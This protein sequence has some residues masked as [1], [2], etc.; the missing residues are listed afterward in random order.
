MAKVVV[1]GGGWSGCAAAIAAR[2]AGAEVILLERTDSLLGTGLVGGI[3]RNNGRFT[4]AEEII[5]LGCGDMIL[6]TDKAARHRDV[7]FPGHEHATLYD[8]GKI[9][10][11]VRHYLQDAGVDI[12]FERR[13][14]AAATEDGTVKA[15]SVSASETVEGDAF[16]DCTGTAGPQVN[17][18]KFGNGCCMCV[19]RCP[20]FGG[21]LSLTGLCGIPE[22]VGYSA[23]GRPGSMS[24]S[25]KLHKGSLHRSIVERLDAEGVCVIPIPE[26][27]GK[28]DVSFKACQQYALDEYRENIVL[29]DTGHAKLMASYFPLELLRRIPGLESARFEDPYAGGKGN[30]IRYMAIAP[31]DNTLKVQGMRNLFCGG[32]KAGTLVG[33]TEAIVTGALA[34]F[35]AAQVALGEKPVELPR[36]LAV[37]DIIAKSNEDIRAREGLARKYTFSGSFYFQRM[38]DAGL[39][40]SNPDQIHERVRKLGLE[41]FLDNGALRECAATVDG[42]PDRE[43]RR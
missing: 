42:K 6:L 24:G 41:G 22:M 8:I 35:N 34:G 21:R 9:E 4:A 40:S 13:I 12:R 5:A 33:H 10:P 16:V 7:R 38:K 11:M 37:G 31:R 27:L 14:S 26:E 3:M 43:E 25:C 28:K 17:C 30:S 36:S 15:C 32:E 20:S 18:T 2:K 19:L 1:V 23:A 39:Y 29:L